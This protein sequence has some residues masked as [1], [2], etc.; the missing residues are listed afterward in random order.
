MELTV[1]TTQRSILILKGPY[2][3]DQQAKIQSLCTGSM[4]VIFIGDQTVDTMDALLIQFSN[5]AST[6]VSVNSSP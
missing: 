5:L 1:L 6:Q 3:A 4:T 2:T